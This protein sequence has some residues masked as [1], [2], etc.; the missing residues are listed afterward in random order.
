MKNTKLIFAIIV[1]AILTTAVAVVSCNKEKQ[2]HKA[3]SAL[4]TSQLSDMDKA[5]MDFGERLK[6]SESFDE[7]MPLDE[8][9]RTFSNYENFLLC[10]ISYNAPEKICDTFEIDLPV[11]NG[12]VRLGDLNQL[13]SSNKDKIFARFN[14]LDNDEKELFCIDSK[15][16]KEKS[17]VESARIQTVV[18]M[19]NGP[20]RFDPYPVLFDSTDY[21]YDFGLLGKCDAYAGQCVGQDAITKL[22]SKLREWLPEVKCEYGM[23]LSDP[24]QVTLL[25]IAFPDATSPNG[26]YAMPYNPNI[27]YPMCISPEEMRWYYESIK[28]MYEDVEDADIL[29]RRIISLSFNETSGG[30][31]TKLCALNLNLYK[32]NCTGGDIE[33]GE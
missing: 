3:E 2:E 30:G 17:T 5:M 19:Q 14:M 1:L 20:V 10:N 9:I 15:V 26:Y 11:N 27:N 22:Q 33:R 4:F 8:A 7:T 31:T 24:E 16:V 13:L 32:V 23:Y 18:Y 25:S 12:M 28:S 29:G 6:S 21:W